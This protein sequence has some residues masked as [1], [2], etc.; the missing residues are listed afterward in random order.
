MKVTLEFDGNEEREE[1]ETALNGWK[2]KSILFDLTQLIRQHEKGWHN[3][4]LNSDS[5]GDWLTSKLEE[6]QVGIN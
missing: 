4:E 6:Y 1:Y 5:L 2:Y 3:E